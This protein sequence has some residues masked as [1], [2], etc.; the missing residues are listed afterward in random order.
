MAGADDRFGEVE[1]LGKPALQVEV[2]PWGYIDVDFYD[3]G[4]TSPIEQPLHLWSGH[5][6]LAGD[7]ALRPPVDE[8]PVRNA[9]QEFVLVP[10]ELGKHLASVEQLLS[11]E[12]LLRP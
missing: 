10:A 6:E 9:G 1:G 12:Q 8:R 2:E 11:S 5:P 7:L 4:G 3:T